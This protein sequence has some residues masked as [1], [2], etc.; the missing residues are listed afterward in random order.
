VRAKLLLVGGILILT[1]LTL[2]N[3]CRDSHEGSGE[4]RYSHGSRAA[5]RI[6][7]DYGGQFGMLGLADSAKA[8]D[9]STL[10]AEAK[11]LRII[12]SPSGPN[13]LEVEETHYSPVGAITYR[14]LLRIRFDLGGGHVDEEIPISGSKQQS[15]FVT[16]PSGS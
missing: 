4:I 7:Y 16:W 8:F 15:F 11:A 12:K 14:G 2:C 3:G 1:I 5:T 10:L 9:G 6:T 13:Q